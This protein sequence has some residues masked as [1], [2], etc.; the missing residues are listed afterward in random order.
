MVGAHV[1][2]PIAISY[3]NA[4]FVDHV[5]PLQYRGYWPRE[6]RLRSTDKATG[7][8]AASNFITSQSSVSN[9]TCSDDVV[10]YA[11]TT[12][13]AMREYKTNM[14]TSRQSVRNAINSRINI[15][16]QRVWNKP[17]Q[18]SLENS[19]QSALLRIEC[20]QRELKPFLSGGMLPPQNRYIFEQ[21]HFHWAD[22]D[23]LGSE[24][25]IDKKKYV[26]L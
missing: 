21:L 5:Q 2:S 15:D 18:Y 24:H 13:I 22:C 12:F 6:N 14:A 26:C 1:Q 25:M 4:I 17:G 23:A 10:S 19:G 11:N 9:E 8:M 16:G 7:E 20:S 3:D